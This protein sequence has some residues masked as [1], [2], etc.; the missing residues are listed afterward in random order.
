MASGSP[1]KPGVNGPDRHAGE[2]V[3]DDRRQP[4]LPGEQSPDERVA[5]GDGDV[6]EERELVWHRMKAGASLAARA[7]R[8]YHA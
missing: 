3:A 8:S 4:D 5:Q 2:Q 6:D 7:A 1:T